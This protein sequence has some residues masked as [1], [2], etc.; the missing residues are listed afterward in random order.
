M[1][2]ISVIVVSLFVIF[3]ALFLG[4]SNLMGNRPF[5]EALSRYNDHRIKEAMSGFQALLYD[6]PYNAVYHWYAARCSMAQKNFTTTMYH[7]E[8]IVRINNYTLPEPDLPDTENFSEKGIQIELLKLYE[9][10][11]LKDKIKSQYEKLM[12][13][14]K[15]NPE[16]PLNL[17]RVYIDERNYT[18]VVQR[19]L[20]KSLSLLPEQGEVLFLL[21]L[22]YYK[23]GKIEE[24]LQVADK[25]VGYDRALADAY[26][27]MGFA[28][29][30]I[31]LRDEAEK[32]FKNAGLCRI[33]RK[34]KSYYL[35][36]I[37]EARGQYDVAI[38][39]AKEA[40]QYASSLHEDPTLEIEAKYL[41]AA[42]AERLD[43]FDKA[44]ELYQK[45]ESMQPG[46][47]DVAN[48]LRYMAKDS[49]SSSKLSSE[50]VNQIINRFKSVK[51]DEFSMLTEKVIIKMGYKV[52]KFELIDDRTINAIGVTS[53]GRE[54]AFF[55]RRGI[56]IIEN[57]HLQSLK[58]YMTGA[59]VQE[60]VFI[61]A[62]DFASNARNSAPAEGIVLVS[63]NDL[64]T[65]LASINN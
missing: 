53:D 32:L 44:V 19:L 46:Y 31:N 58:M 18:D 24:A 62:T 9:A 30:K 47:R 43:D 41:Y 57:K 13:L 14:D 11:K 28:R 17:A 42:L 37:A 15:S 33:F 36:K 25:A 12:E 40:D 23:N 63:G 7:L 21:A 26:F 1:F 34:S 38:S 65:V 22:V 29:Y 52:K 4:K 54:T 16:Y 2:F 59:R 10:L 45:I 49:V 6:E 27:I 5:K 61:T 3:V 50:E 51:I 56:G 8:N 55:S 48:K 35:A 39:Y 60:G 20:E 64:A